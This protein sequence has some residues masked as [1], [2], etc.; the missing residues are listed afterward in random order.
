MKFRS[1]TAGTIDGI[2]FYKAAANTGTHVGSLWNAD[3]NPAGAGDL[4]RR[5][6]V[7]L[8]AGAIREPGPIQANTT[9]V[10]GYLAPNGHYS[11]NGPDLATGVDN[12]PLHAIANSV[13]RNGV[14]NYSSARP[15]RPTTTSPPTTGSTSSSPAAPAP[16]PGQVTG[17]SATGGQGQATVNWTAPASNGG[18]PITSYRVTPYIGTTAQAPVSV[19]AP[20]SSKTITGLTGGTPYTFKVAAI[21][22]I[23]TGPDSS[24]SNVVTPTALSAP[25]HRPAL[26]RP[27]ARNRRR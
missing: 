13:T 12:P 17:V 19:T 18:S 25:G 26:V 9:Y 16:A 1:D 21:N 15:S 27:A 22:T 4:Q 23:G 7:G 3:G 6:R 5:D 10:A 11:V 14:Y 24:A 20:A 2:R 8:A